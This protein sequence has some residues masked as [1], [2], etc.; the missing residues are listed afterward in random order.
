MPEKESEATEVF[1]CGDA[2]KLIAILPETDESFGIE[3]PTKYRCA[4]GF[5]YFSSYSVCLV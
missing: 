1:T 5:A 3:L 2:Q 4:A